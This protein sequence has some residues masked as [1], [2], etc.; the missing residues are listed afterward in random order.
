MIL[1]PRTTLG[2]LALTADQLRRRRDAIRESATALAIRSPVPPFEDAPEVEQP[3]VAFGL[4]ASSS[5]LAGVRSEGFV[6]VVFFVEGGGAFDAG[7]ALP[8]FRMSLS[9]VV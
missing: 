4:P 7:G 1:V 6:G 5:S 3:A 2:H 9:S 8:P